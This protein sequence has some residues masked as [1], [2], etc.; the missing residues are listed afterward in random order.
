M[1]SLSILIL[2]MFVSIPASAQQALWGG[3]DIKSP[4]ILPDN[5]VTFRVQ[6]PQAVKVEITG[7]FLPT[8]KQET[9]FGTF[10]VAGNADLVKNAQGV[11]EFTTPAPLAPELY[12]SR[13]SLTE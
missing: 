6:A 11:W 9:P 7:D 10:D 5:K 4:E 2:A 1:K 3:Q 13:S 12:S 8:Q